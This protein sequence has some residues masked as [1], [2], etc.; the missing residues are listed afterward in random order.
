M[1]NIKSFLGLAGYYRRFVKD[2]SK[3]ANP[4][5]RL[6][7]KGAQFK[8]S[9]ECEK[10]FKE[11]KKKLTTESVLIIPEQGHGYSIYCD[12]SGYE[13]GSVLMQNQGV[14]AFGSRQ[15][16]DHEKN[17]PTHDLELASVVFVLKVCRL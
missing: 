3:L 1:F 9:E 13:L 2:F 7:Q 14:V 16:N 4:I 5:T 6:T 8:W 12:A 11:M 10:A 15:L 17:C